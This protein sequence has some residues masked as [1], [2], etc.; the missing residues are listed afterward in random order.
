MASRETELSALP[1]ASDPPRG[2][3]SV[4]LGRLIGPYLRGEPRGLVP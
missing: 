2:R 3:L 1:E 4:M